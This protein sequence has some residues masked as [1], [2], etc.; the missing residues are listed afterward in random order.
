[1]IISKDDIVWK[2]LFFSKIVIIIINRI[3]KKIQS[4]ILAN[5][6]FFILHSFILYSKFGSLEQV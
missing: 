3:R 2:I 1:M 4:P 5:F 6:P